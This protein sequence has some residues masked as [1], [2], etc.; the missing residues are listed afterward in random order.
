M[1]TNKVATSI[2]LEEHLLEKIKN[3]AAI[4]HRSFNSQI[5]F[6]VEQYVEEFEKNAES[7]N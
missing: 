6:I 2:R 3:I 4:E 5:E 1:P 7:K